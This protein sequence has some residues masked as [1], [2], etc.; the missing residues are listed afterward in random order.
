[1][2]G[3]IVQPNRSISDSAM[4]SLKECVQAFIEAQGSALRATWLVDHTSVGTLFAQAVTAAGGKV[5]AVFRRDNTPE[6]AV[7]LEGQQDGGTWALGAPAD[8]VHKS[9]PALSL[10]EREVVYFKRRGWQRLVKAVNPVFVL[11]TRPDPRAGLGEFWHYADAAGL[12]PTVLVP[13]CFAPKPQI[14]R[15]AKLTSSTGI[16]PAPTRAAMSSAAVLAIRDDNEAG[17]LRGLL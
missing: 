15:D 5:E 12:V 6:R 16:I 3:L 14:I 4:R 1:M 8:M 13:D 10:E 7:D 9:R 17:T 2:R 11:Q